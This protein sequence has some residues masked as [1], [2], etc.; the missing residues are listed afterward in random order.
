[1]SK[2]FTRVPEKPILKWKTPKNITFEEAEEN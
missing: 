1:M 2:R